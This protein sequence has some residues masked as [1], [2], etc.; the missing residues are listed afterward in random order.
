VKCVSANGER[1]G[2]RE[3]TGKKKEKEMGNRDDRQWRITGQ[4]R[5]LDGDEQGTTKH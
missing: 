4:D 2:K 5:G 1:D 3:T